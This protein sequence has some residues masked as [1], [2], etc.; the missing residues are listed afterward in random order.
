MT[1]PAVFPSSW[2]PKLAGEERRT[3][4][5]VFQGRISYQK[6]SGPMAYSCLEADWDAWVTSTNAV[7]VK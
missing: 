1:H 6:A 2:T 5:Q 3:V 7:R 4:I